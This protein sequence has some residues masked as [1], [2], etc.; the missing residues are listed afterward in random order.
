M[1]LDIGLIAKKVVEGH[2]A[3]KPSK[4]PMT[5]SVPNDRENPTLL[6]AADICCASVGRFESEKKLGRACVRERVMLCVCTG[7]RVCVCV[8]C[9]GTSTP[10]H[11][12]KT[13]TLGFKGP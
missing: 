4:S 1:D 2:L 13:R 11:T 3:I 6:F 8:F 7:A 10:T 9:V 12:H 5:V